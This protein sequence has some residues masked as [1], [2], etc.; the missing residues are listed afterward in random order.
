MIIDATVETKIKVWNS[1]KNSSGLVPIYVVTQYGDKRKFKST[2]LW[3]K[4]SHSGEI[5]P[6]LNHIFNPE[7]LPISL[8][9]LLEKYDCSQANKTVIEESIKRFKELLGE[10]PHTV[11]LT[12]NNLLKLKKMM[13]EKS[14]SDSSISIR[15][16]C[17]RTLFNYSKS[18]GLHK[19][20]NPFIRGLIPTPKPKKKIV[21]WIVPDND[22]YKLQLCLGGVDFADAIMIIRKRLGE[23]YHDYIRYKNRRKG[24]VQR[25]YVTKH[26]YTLI[27]SLYDQVKNKNLLTLRRRQNNQLK[28]YKLSS[29]SPRYQ[30]AQMLQQMECPKEIIKD[31]L[32][33]AKKDV[34]DRYLR[35][36]SIKKWV[37]MLSGH[38]FRGVKC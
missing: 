16:R 22:I 34:T 35:D 36:S 24:T 30:T 18:I 15:L 21:K 14:N 13:V 32:G 37:I 11:H 27:D 9:E 19:M 20:E 17:L 3:I 6:L 26:S 38:V 1:K 31:I 28:P 7:S 12:L 23:G 4:P 5:L 33:H 2:K 8:S 29:K 10:E 25:I